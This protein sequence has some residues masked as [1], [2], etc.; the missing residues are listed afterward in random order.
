MAVRLRPA[1]RSGLIVVGKRWPPGTAP[2]N[3]LTDP[4]LSA[5]AKL[6]LRPIGCYPLARV[7]FA[8]SVAGFRSIGESMRRLICVLSSGIML[9]GCT[10][11]MSSLRSFGVSTGPEQVKVES[12][13]AGAEARSSEGPT[14][15]T[16]CEFAM[17]AGSDFVVTVAMNGYQPVTVPVRPESPGGRLQ[18]NP[19]HVELQPAAPMVPAKKTPAKKKPKQGTATQQ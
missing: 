10:G 6:D 2:V 18:P 11:S 19:I 1:P 17:P 5:V 14:C 4:A 12:E 7:S 16:P 15:Q 3:S 8:N 13:P 9:A